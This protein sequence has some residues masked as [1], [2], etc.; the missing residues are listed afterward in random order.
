MIHAAIAFVALIVSCFSANALDIEG[1][2]TVVDGDSITIQ[3]RLFGIDA[4]EL[5]QTCKSDAGVDY[6]CGQKASDALLRLIGG[7][8][9]RCIKRDQDTQYGRPVAIC[10]AGEIDI[11]GAMVEQGWAV[12]YRK[13][14]TEYVAKE[15]EA[16]LAKRG[17]WAGTFEPPAEYRARLKSG[18]PTLNSM[19][20]IGSGPA[21]PAYA[22]SASPA[23]CPLP[24]TTPDCM[25]KGNINRKGERIYHLPGT[26]SYNATQISGKGERYF[27][28]EEEAVACGWR[29][30]GS[31]R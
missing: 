8:E 17:M 14:S 20:A 31:S 24:S 10:H 16:R 3:I 1:R 26:S 25:I 15:D 19:P 18:S 21:V 22:M 27:C 28:S 4:P 11:G 12:A 9:V 29:R 7:N 6:P 5:R 30:A 2:P 23:V 13:Y